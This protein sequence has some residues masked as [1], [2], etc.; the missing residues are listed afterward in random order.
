M[1][2]TAYYAEVASKI[3]QLTEW[4]LSGN[5]PAGTPPAGPPRF[6]PTTG[7][8]APT[9]E[10]IWITSTDSMPDVVPGGRAGVTVMTSL[11]NAARSLCDFG[12]PWRLATAEEI[13]SN[14]DHQ[15]RNRLAMR[16]ADAKLDKTRPFVVQ[17]PG[18]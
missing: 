1:D 5:A 9:V 3:V 17:V 10:A 4:V 15:E 13:Q 2:I 6:D 8:T 7:R 14:L 11:K 18:A 12:R 16:A